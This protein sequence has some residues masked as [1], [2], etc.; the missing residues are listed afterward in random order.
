MRSGWLLCSLLVLAA[1]ALAS[2]LNLS[3]HVGGSQAV[4]VGPG[5]TVNWQVRGELDD[6]AHQ[7]LAFVLFDLSFDGGDLVQAASPSGPPMTSF[8]A[9]QGLTNPAGFGG[10]VVDGDLIQVGGAQ[11][12]INNA[13]ASV[14]NGAVTLGVASP[15]VP[16]T[17]VQGSLTA[18]YEPGVYTLSLSNAMANVVR[19]GETGVPFW[20][21]DAAGIGSVDDLTIEV[22]AL[23]T[24]VAS[25]SIAGLGQQ[26][27]SLDAGTDNA[28]RQYFILGT[29]TGQTPGFTLGNGL[30]I[31]LNL[32]AYF[33]VLVDLPNLLISPQ[34]GVLDANGQ[35]TATYSVPPGTP[36]EL[37]GFTLEHAFVL[38]NPKDFASNAE[39]LLLTP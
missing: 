26:V 9:P 15:G 23:T 38:L 18:P 34:I 13:F 32:D 6:A 11:N 29:F 2:D 4:V 28:F 8:D 19:L 36:P 31:P 5:S 33:F 39:A 30:H 17:L 35:A 14:P 7:G 37:A 24:N 22:K 21:V 27:L 16:V 10:T 20:A 12:T 1:P 25:A 3:V